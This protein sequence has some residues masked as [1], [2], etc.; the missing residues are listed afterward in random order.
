MFGKTRVTVAGMGEG[1]DIF[2]RG[3]V[4]VET[5]TVSGK[6]KVVKDKFPLADHQIIERNALEVKLVKQQ[7][8]LDFLS[9]LKNK[10]MDA[11]VS[12]PETAA[13]AKAAA[14][15]VK[16]T[17]AAISR[18]T[19]VKAGGTAEAP[20]V[21]QAVAQVDEPEI[22]SGE[23]TKGYIPSDV[24]ESKGTPEDI[25]QAE[26]KKVGAQQYFINKDIEHQNWVNNMEARGTIPT[27]VNRQKADSKNFAKNPI[28]SP[29]Y[30][31][32]YKKALSE[33]GGD[34]AKAAAVAAT[35]AKQFYK[36][37]PAIAL[38]GLAATQLDD[39]LNKSGLGKKKPE[40][41]TK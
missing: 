31:Q 22:K 26:I 13:E 24:P 21:T 16:N 8:R 29:K 36:R 12:V 1:D 37:M 23:G 33:L 32:V 3:D 9:G 18:L 35:V 17:K 15:D 34:A 6:R 20:V 39:I 40:D 4:P 10:M 38:A 30:K 19:N 27:S 5:E 14:A 25:K 28:D 7:N 41:Y 2:I 11:G